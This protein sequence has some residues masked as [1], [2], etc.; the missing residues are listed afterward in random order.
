M[1]GIASV[2]HSSAYWVIAAGSFGE[3]IASRTYPAVRNDSSAA[4]A[5]APV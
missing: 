5:M 2:R 3:M 4:F 1:K